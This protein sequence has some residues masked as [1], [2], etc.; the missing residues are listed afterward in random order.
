MTGIRILQGR[1]KHLNEVSKRR[2]LL[3][4]LGTTLTSRGY[5]RYT[6]RLMSPDGKGNLILNDLSAKG[7][8]M[9]IESLIDFFLT[10]RENNPLLYAF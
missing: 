6:L 7:S 5:R 1:V 10:D 4:S 2:F 8:L 3:S 9:I